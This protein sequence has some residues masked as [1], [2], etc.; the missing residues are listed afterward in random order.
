MHNLN[1]FKRYISIS[2]LMI[3]IQT[4]AAHAALMELLPGSTLA[5]TSDSV[6]LDWVTSCNKNS[7]PLLDVTP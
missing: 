5:S 6:S 4:S 1:A 2:L 3:L 7:K